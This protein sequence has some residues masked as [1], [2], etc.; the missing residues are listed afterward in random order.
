M[1]SHKKSVSTAV[2]LEQF[3]NH[4]VGE[5]YQARHVVRQREP[6]HEEVNITDMTKRAPVK[7]LKHRKD[8]KEKRKKNDKRRRDETE[9][10]STKLDKY[11]NSAALRRFRM[12]LEKIN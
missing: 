2:D 7:R 12:E 1:S 6:T 8:K 3:R 10:G 11:L 9:D 4:T 5:G